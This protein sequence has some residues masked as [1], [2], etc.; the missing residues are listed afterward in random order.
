MNIKSTKYKV[1]HT[2]RDYP[3][4][5]NSDIALTLKIWKLYFPQ[6]IY[7]AKNG[8][9]YVEITHLYELPRED[10]V[11]RYRAKFN[12]QGLY[13]PTDRKVFEQRK[14]NIKFWQESLGYSYEKEMRNL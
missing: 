9:D 8:K 12:E 1:E 14:L 4:T 6:Y 7:T 10:H 13:L 5:R 11:K 2:L 3:E